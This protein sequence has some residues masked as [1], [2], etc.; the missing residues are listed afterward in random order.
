METRAS[1]LLIGSFVILAVLALFGFVIWLA[2]VDIDREFV[3]YDIYFEK[4]V[5]GLGIGG[6]VRYR[7]LKVGSVVNIRI[8]PE[9]PTQARVRVEIDS[10]VPIR[11]GDS[12]SLR[13]QGITGVS[14]VDI[15]GATAGSPPLAP[16]S[17]GGVAVIASRPSQIERL[18]QGAPELI[19]RATLLVEQI[20][21]LFSDENQ[22]LIVGML[23]DLGALT[24][25]LASRRENLERI[26]DNFD[27]ASA[28]IASTTA[29][30]NE[31][32]VKANLVLDETQGAFS[33]VR[34]VLGNAEGM[35]EQD[36]RPLIADVRQTAQSFN[37]LANNASS[38]LE[39]N[40]DTL[41]EVALDG[42]NEFTRFVAETRLLVASLSR[43]LDRFESDGARA[44]FRD[45][46]GDFT[47]E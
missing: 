43:V 21:L 31:L 33:D 5:S 22:V 18:V 20:T 12:A 28:E 37:R 10:R 25:S 9:D 23:S 27:H 34:V 36:L 17:E 38:I 39:K 32:A 13:L 30:L 2:K 46:E 47:P 11:E 16:P 41:G 35:V 3:L 14:F 19:N 7:G 4:S 44:F 6:D 29:L 1:H 40:K 15:E 26:V 8:D 45:S 24:N 42:L